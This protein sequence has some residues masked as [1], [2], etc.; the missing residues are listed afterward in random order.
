MDQTIVQKLRFYHIYRHANVTG[1]AIACCR[2]RQFDLLS[3]TATRLFAKDF[4]AGQFKSE[5]LDKSGI[6]RCRLT[7]LWS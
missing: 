2:R 5:F 1:S 6:G 4:P 3:G 7:L